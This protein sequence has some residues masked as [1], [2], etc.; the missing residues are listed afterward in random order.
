MRFHDHLWLAEGRQVNLRRPLLPTRHLDARSNGIDLYVECQ[1]LDPHMT[2]L[3]PLFRF[4][5]HPVASNEADAHNNQPGGDE[6]CGSQQG[7][8]NAWT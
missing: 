1:I 4:L 2:G 5:R 7:S 3:R 8:C 6:Q